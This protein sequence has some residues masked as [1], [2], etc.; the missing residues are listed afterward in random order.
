MKIKAVSGIMLTLLLTSMLTLAF[1]VVPR[2]TKV[3]AVEDTNPPVLL[4]IWVTPTLIN[5]GESITI[6]ADVTD[7]LSGVETVFPTV[8]S[9]TGKQS[10]QFGGL[11]YNSSSGLWEKEV[12]IPQY[13]EN[14][15]WIVPYVDCRDFAQNYKRYEH[16]VDFIANFTVISLTPDMSPPTL[17]VI[18][19]VPNVVMDNESIK[20]YAEVTDDLSGVKFVF[21]TLKSPSETSGSTLQ[22]GGLEYN[23]SSGLW[24]KEVLIPAY[25]ESGVWIIPFVEVGDNV[26]NRD[27]LWYNIDFIANFTVISS[28]PDTTPPALHDIWVSP[29]VINVGES[30][31][32]HAN[33]TDDLSGVD[34][35]FPTFLS[36]SG[37]QRI[38][39]GGLVYNSSSELWEREVTLPIYSETGKW[40]V[41]YVEVGDNA[42]NRAFYRYNID[43]IVVFVIN[44]TEIT[45]TVDIDPDTLNL[46]SKGEWITCYIELPEGYNV[47]DIDVST[48]M[49]ND[50]IPVSLLDVP[51][52]KP[53][54]TEI[55]DYDNDG[56]PDLMVKF[57]RTELTSHIHNVL[58]IE[59]GNVTLT[60]TGEVAGTPFEGSDSIRVIC[61]S[62]GHSTRKR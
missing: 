62:T 10:I 2:V 48:I 52:P 54:P 60:I 22:F 56:V 8:Q 45:A 4:D 24:E 21:P 55:G 46:K 16:D 9:P 3:F 35:V 25:S 59:Y 7:D 27:W 6:Y 11:E 26:E 13:S 57:N 61:P 34:F 31:T 15:T 20:I 1:N 50:T 58:G 39:F 30:V 5:D 28:F 18:W 14:G 51:A 42:N 37:N 47:S 12:T 49:L 40:I 36:P 19:I 53:V 41:D 23:S 33:V 29:G 17:N 32:V 43:Y 44:P 38:Q